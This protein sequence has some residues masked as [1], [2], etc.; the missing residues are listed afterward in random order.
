MNGVLR[1]ALAV[2]AV[3]VVLCITIAVFLWYGLQDTEKRLVHTQVQLADNTTELADAEWQLAS[4]ETL[5]DTAETQ[6]VDTEAQLGT[7][8]A[9]LDVAMD[10]LAMTTARLD[11]TNTELALARSQLGTAENE[12]TQTL[13]QYARL[14]NQI[15][16][17]LGLTPEDKQSFMTPDNPLVS[18]RVQEITGG[19]SEDVDEYWRDC[20]L[21][22]R[23]VV[24]NI[25]YS[26]DSHMPV[27]PED[28]SGELTWWQSCWRLPQ[29]TLE[30]ETGDCEDMATLLASMLRSYDE[31]S[32][33]VWVLSI[34]SSDPELPGHAAVAFPVAGGKL[35]ILDPAGN[36]YTGYPYRSLRSERASVAV[37]RWF[38]HWEDDLPG[39]RIVE[40]FSETDYQE[41]SSTAEF[42]AWLPE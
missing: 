1:I 32:Y 41:F 38:S 21:L 4:T 16:I 18:A 17:R 6:L 19:Y 28:I 33:E 9:Q 23:W 27:L 31:G 30:D 39:A 2:A 42:L 5:L 29:E 36:Y 40:A 22:Y 26:Y 3:L 25:S 24:D 13:G 34:Y 8:R 20:E 15:S 7:T 10:Q 35:T 12:N 37:S 14:R 11:T